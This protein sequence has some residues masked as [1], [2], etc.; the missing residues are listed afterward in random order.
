MSSA[1]F[2]ARASL[3]RDLRSASRGGRD[4][5]EAKP[6]PAA[7]GVGSPSGLLSSAFSRIGLGVDATASRD[8]RASAPSVSFAA[9]ASRSALFGVGGNTGGGGEMSSMQFRAILVR[10]E[11]VFWRE[12]E[13]PALTLRVLLR[14]F[15]TVLANL[16]R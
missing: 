3:Y 16:F 4:S 7:L 14:L 8:P 10:S 5:P 9:P 13:R 6:P 11:I 12:R 15:R 1:G 2:S